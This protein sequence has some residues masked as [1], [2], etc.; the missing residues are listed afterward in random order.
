M[1]FY[2]TDGREIAPP[3][4]DSTL[5]ISTGQDNVRNN[6]QWCCVT[7]ETEYTTGFMDRL[8]NDVNFTK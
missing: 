3:I 4:G 5:S 7:F 8:Y 2:H 1:V 6:I